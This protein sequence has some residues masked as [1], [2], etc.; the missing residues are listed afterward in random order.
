MGAVIPCTMY[1]VYWSDHLFIAVGI[2]KLSPQILQYSDFASHI[3][4]PTNQCHSDA[5]GLSHAIFEF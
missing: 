4:I 2:L 1:G 3:R 5:I